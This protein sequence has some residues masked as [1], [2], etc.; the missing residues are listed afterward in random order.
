MKD[1]FKFLPLLFFTSFVINGQNLHAQHEIYV[2]SISWH[3]GILIP[4]D[5]F[6]DSLWTEDHN[7]SDAAYLEIG[8]GEADY[9]T[10]DGFHLWY[11]IKSVFWPTPSVLHINAID[12]PVEEYY[13]DTE[14]VKTEVSD[15]QLQQLIGY[16]TRGFELDKNGNIIPVAEGK[17]LRSHFFRSRES[18]Y[19]PKNSNVWA[20][21]ALKEAGF[22]VSPFRL[23][24]TGC[25]INK[26]ADFGELVVE[27]KI[28][29]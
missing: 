5:T 12:R 1:F 28:S 7:Y 15:E 9:Y 21:K 26:A 16:I 13:F 27:K 11:A 22:P 3:T 20:A 14:V 2:S 6:P 19:F 23:Q 8:W 10:H 4:A 25:V 24:T 17:N 18:Y 29:F